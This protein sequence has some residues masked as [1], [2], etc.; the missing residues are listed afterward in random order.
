MSLGGDIHVLLTHINVVRG[1]IHESAL[2]LLAESVFS[3]WGKTV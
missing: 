2:L 3:S 1:D